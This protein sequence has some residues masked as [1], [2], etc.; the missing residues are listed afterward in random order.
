MHTLGRQAIVGLL[1]SL[2]FFAAPLPSHA[3][4]AQPRYTAHENGV[5][6]YEPAPS[7]MDKE[8]G[9]SI[10]YLSGF[11]YY[12]INDQGEYTV[13]SVEPSGQV[14][15]A[16]YCVQACKVIR[17]SDGLRL[18]K[19]QSLLIGSVFDDAIAGLLSNSNP[20]LR[21]VFVPSRSPL[22]QAVPSDIE[23]LNGGAVKVSS[24]ER[25]AVY[26]P[27]AGVIVESGYHPR[28][29]QYVKIRHG[30]GIETIIGSLDRRLV[31]KD[32]FVTQQTIVGHTHCQPDCFAIFEVRIEGRVVNP[33]PFMVPKSLTHNYYVL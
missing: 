3:G 12:G 14:L 30:A 33:L 6:Y 31:M 24:A 1:T 20:I 10:A 21:Q 13:V 29:Q 9:V 4:S 7:P 23:S 19:R 26:P 22:P 11:R 27:A 16:A 18:V 5:Y 32:Y 25:E 8:R 15:W 28:Y 17:F 2:S